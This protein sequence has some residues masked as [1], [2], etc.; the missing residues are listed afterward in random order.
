MKLRGFLGLMREHWP[1][2]GELSEQ[3]RLMSAWGD[4]IATIA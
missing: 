4:R 1:Q 2:I 3:G